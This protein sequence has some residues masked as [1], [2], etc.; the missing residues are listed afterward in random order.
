MLLLRSVSEKF[1]K[2]NC[3]PQREA[4]QSIPAWDRNRISKTQR[5]DQ[6]DL[7]VRCSYHDL[8][9]RAVVQDLAL[10]EPE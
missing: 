8:S 10:R 9:R 1:C 4:S 6:T 7:F 3:R 2:D 5:A